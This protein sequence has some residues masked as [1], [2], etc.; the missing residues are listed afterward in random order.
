[1]SSPPN[2][3]ETAGRRQGPVYTKAREACMHYT[4]S[5]PEVS[6]ISAL[7]IQRLQAN[8][9]PLLLID[10]RLPEEQAVSMIQGAISL[11]EFEA[12]EANGE[13]SAHAL[14][15]TETV[16]VPYCTIGYRSGTYAEKL[17]ARGYKDV[18]NG[19]GVVMWT[20]D[21]GKSMHCLTT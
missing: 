19:E 21:I 17:K 2:R 9:V 3:R 11:D 16:L 13:Y 5:F 18:R 6:T 14:A 8:S 15:A 4:G 20:H 7:E 12:A 10:V 1:M